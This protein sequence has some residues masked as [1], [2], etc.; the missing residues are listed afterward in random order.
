MEIIIRG[1]SGGRAALL[2][3]GR[4][5]LAVTRGAGIRGRSGGSAAL[6]VGGGRNLA[7]ARGAAGVPPASLT[8]AR[9]LPPR[10]SRAALP[11]DLPRIISTPMA[12]LAVP[13]SSR[14][15][16]PVLPAMA[17]TPLPSTTCPVR[18]AGVDVVEKGDVCQPTMSSKSYN[19][20]HHK[21]PQKEHAE[22]KNLLSNWF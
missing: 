19:V 22:G 3:G 20:D 7:V 18:D 11:P 13:T 16:P 10:T 12:S 15:T 8:T 21:N 1:R 17:A 4:R 5:N 9:F 14:A 2:V 6:L